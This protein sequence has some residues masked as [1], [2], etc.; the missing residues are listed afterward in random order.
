MKFSHFFIHRPIFAAVLSIFITLLGGIALFTLPIAQYPE[1]TPPSIFVFAN[2][3]GANAETV[4]NTVA[5]PLEEMING[6]ENMLYMSASCSSDG[7]MRLSVTFAVGTDPDK[8]QVLVQNRVAQAEPRLPEEV[9]RL[10]VTVRKRSPTIAMLVS[11]VSPS[12]KYDSVYLSNYGYLRVQ[13]TLRRLPGVGDTIIFG[14]RDYAMRIWLDPNKISARDLT[15]SDITA[16]IRRQNVEVAA[17]LFGQSPQPPENLF[18]LTARTRG[19]LSTPEEFGDIILKT[20]VGGQITRLR[21]VAR[22]ELGAS[23]YSIISRLNGEDTATIALFQQPGANA[24]ET[25]NA[26]VRAMEE[27]KKDFPEGLEYRIS[28]DTS[29]FVRESIRAVIHTLIEAMILVIIVVVLFLQNWRAS[30]IPLVAVPVSLIGTF[31]VMSALGF[32][33]NNLSLFGLVLAI[34]IV[35]DD[36]IVVVENVERHIAEGLSAVAATEKAMEEVSGAVIAIGLVLSAV[37]I[38]TAFISGI[39]GKFYQ[40]F[41]LTIAVST[42]ISAFVSLTLS[43]AMAALLLQ[44]HH[45][46]KD[47]LGRIIHFSFDWLFNGFNRVFE[48]GRSTYVKVLGRTLRHTGV[49]LLLYGGLLFLTW[50]GFRHVPTGF[51][52][53]QDKGNIFCYMQLPDGASLQRTEAIS[54]RVVEIAKNTPGISYVSEFAGLSLINLGNSA[55]ASTLFIR[56]SPFEERVGKGLTGDAVIADLRHRIA[57]ANIQDAFIGVFGPPPVDGLGLL[58]GF[59]LQVE[60]RS[61]AG[62]EAL[63]AAT[64][65]LAAAANQDPHISGALSTFR[66]GVP[67]VYLDVDR[68]KAESMQVPLNNVWETLSTYLGSL[69]VNDFTYLGRPYRVV[70]QADAPFR[71]QPEDVLNLKTRNAA[72]EMVPLGTL[73]RVKDITAPVLVGRYNMFPTAELSGNTPPGVSSGDVIRAM[74]ALAERVLPPGMGMEWTELTYLQIQAGN[75]AIYIFPLCVLMMF[76]VLA[77]QYESWSLPLAIILIVPMCLLFAIAG[78]WMRGLDNNLFVQIGFVVLMGLACKNAILIVE[79]AKQ[80]EDAGRDRVEAA[81][82]A[83]R[84][85]LRPILM[86]SLAFT[87]G[88]IPLMLSKGAGAEMRVAIGTA[89]F[90]GMIGVTAFGVILTPVFYVVIRRVLE[91]REKPAEQ[92]GKGTGAAGANLAILLVGAGLAVLLSGCVVGPD[93]KQPQTSVASTY[94]NGSQTNLSAEPAVAT[95]WQGFN[96]E[97][98]NRLIDRGVAENHDLRIATA[99]LREAR[100]Q[101]TGII[102]QTLPSVTANGGYTKERRSIESSAFPLSSSQRD[103]ETYEASFD[104]TWELSFFG[105]AQRAIQAGSAQLAAAEA[106]RRDVLVSLMAEVAR[107][108]FE[109]RGG[110]HQL[111]VARRNAENQRESLLI[112]TERFRAGRTAELDV[113]R[114]QAQLDSTLATIPPLETAIQRTIYRLSVLTGQQPTALE[115][116]LSKPKPL[117]TLPVLANIGKPE[118]LLR[119]RPDIR[120]AERSLA[121]ATALVGLETADL[122][123]RITFNGSV[124][125]SASD[126]SRLGKAGASTYS[127]GPNITWAAFDLGRVRARIKAADA[128]TE[129]QLA[130][131]ERTVLT[132]LEETEGALVD[133][134]KTH[135]R[136]DHL[137]SAALAAGDAVSLANQRYESGIAD[138]LT[139]LDAQRTQLAIE[140]QLAESQTRTATSLIA[141]YKALGGGW[142]IEQSSSPTAMNSSPATPKNE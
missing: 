91:R 68:A 71:R 89:V 41:A 92:T 134:G 65:Q 111:N 76:L 21:D 11:L 98:L 18:Q 93:Y 31:A 12:G 115:A 33:L 96:D 3:P 129:A 34:G 45:A 49:A 108:Y 8:A 97:T 7:Q 137:A 125:V 46:P 59:K 56:L 124:G 43:P 35:V 84:L 103:L 119:R 26:I 62:F 55:N 86:T 13:D 69:Y 82:E 136:R 50:F 30:I 110:Q 128:R 105:R 24:V 79:F 74:E 138:F 78:V 85:R 130:A 109:L 87:F 139:V 54:Q 73:V 48:G 113:A 17:G 141:V 22:I 114:A 70:A 90:W 1:I 4:A 39:T 88:V 131:Y 57:Q 126:F 47:R 142:E 95:W 32:S 36:A 133:F 120:A 104:A 67:Q 72:G 99:R 106:Q 123:P 81:M 40:Q 15:A 52:P 37:F 6:V 23:D 135:T 100:A 80:L 14:A 51:I 63:Q 9:R 94:A 5:T 112:A 25:A 53:P 127:F 58:G 66:A 75:T 20:D 16:A 29:A 77:A 28:Y 101:R 42:L 116:E 64:A 19:R 118:D 117:P 107:N 38:P 60:D 2:Y 102:L 121:A 83:S 44:P 122:F 140:E 132:A 61:A 27:L 10:G